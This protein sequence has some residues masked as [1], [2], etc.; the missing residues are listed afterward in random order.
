MKDFAPKAVEIDRE[1][2]TPEFSKHGITYCSQLAPTGFWVE[3]P[4]GKVAPTYCCLELG[5]RGGHRWSLKWRGRELSEG[6]PA[7][8]GE[9][10]P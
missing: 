8:K 3:R 10:F 6:E 4:G 5:H 7:P 1:E 2:L 9:P